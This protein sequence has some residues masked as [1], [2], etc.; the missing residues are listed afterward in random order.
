MRDYTRNTKKVIRWRTSEH[1]A[2][3]HKFHRD[4]IID[5]YYNNNNNKKHT[6]VIIELNDYKMKIIIDEYFKR[7]V[8]CE[9][10]SRHKKIMV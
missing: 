8:R 10:R 5:K 1:V 9:S 4:R 7:F 3:S 6:E 2:V